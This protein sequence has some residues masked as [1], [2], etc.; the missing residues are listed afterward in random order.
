MI[1]PDSLESIAGRAFWFCDSLAQISLPD[2]VTSIGWEAFRDCE[3]LTEVTIPGSVS[4]I[5]KNAFD[6]CPEDLVLTVERD[7]YAS[8]YARD[9]GIDYAYEDADDWLFE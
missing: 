4:S 7:S 9:N 2:G 5:G 3:S 6:G 8:D 1:L